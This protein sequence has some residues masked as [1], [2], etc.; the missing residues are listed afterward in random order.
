M[1][2]F[3]YWA[4]LPFVV[5]VCCFLMSSCSSDDGDEQKDSSKSIVGEWISKD[6]I[7][8]QFRA[9]GTGRYI[10]LKDEPGYEPEHP[11][12]VIEY[13]NDPYEFEYNVKDGSLTMKE[14]YSDGYSV[15]V[16]YV[17]VS[18]DV[19]QFRQT[20]YNDDGGEWIIAQ[21]PSWETYL[22]WK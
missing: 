3:L 16:C 11:Q 20:K 10:C 9:N 6:G 15:Y 4:F 17:V 12:A 8:Y 19:L 7:Y 21:R 13:P 14:F 1:R 5:L 22:R 18:E 2:K